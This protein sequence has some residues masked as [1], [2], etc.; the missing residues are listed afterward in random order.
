MAD[1]RH[2]SDASVASD[3]P[4]AKEAKSSSFEAAVPVDSN[5]T[6]ATAPV[7]PNGP[8][9]LNEANS[10]E[11]TAYAWSNKKKW[12]VLTVV[13]LCQTSMSKYKSNFND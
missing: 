7:N 5:L 12:A 2:A 3:G 6:S 4:G 1:L 9:I 13:A 8:L 10:I 11:Q